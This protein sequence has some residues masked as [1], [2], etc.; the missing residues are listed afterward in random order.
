[1]KVRANEV[2]FIDGH[3]R[4]VGEEFD[5]HGKPAPYMT[6]LDGE[7]EGKAP[8]DSPLTDEELRGRLAEYGVKV[9]PQTG[10]KKMIALLAEAE[11]KTPEE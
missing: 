7:A 8:E 9:A 4:R 6:V 10:R 1:M 3:R 5:Y 2:C 11:G